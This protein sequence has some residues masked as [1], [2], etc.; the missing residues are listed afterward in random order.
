MANPTIIVTAGASD[1]NSYCS[2]A[3]AD[4]FHLE[5][6]PVAATWADA[7][8]SERTAALIWATRLLDSLYEW[9]G[10]VVTE[11]QAL[12]WPRS[13]LLYRSGYSV[14]TTVIPVE[15]QR[16][17]AEFARQLMVA[18]RTADNDVAAQGISSITAGPVSIDFDGSA[19]AASATTVPDI[20][21]SMIPPEWGYVRSRSATLDLIRC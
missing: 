15:L 11:T 2:L 13:G 9:E 6:V 10:S 19:K 12:L 20:V 3:V 17:T 8:V 14:P 5:R 1:A 7:S 18:D 4:Q 21:R 16:A